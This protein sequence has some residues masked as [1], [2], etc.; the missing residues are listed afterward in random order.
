MRAKD[1][2]I[3]NE[4]SIFCA[5]KNNNAGLLPFRNLF[6]LESLESGT[7]L[8]RRLDLD[9]VTFENFKSVL[10]GDYSR[11]LAINYDLAGL[12]KELQKYLLEM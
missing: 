9:N 12:S 7:C 6:S 5:K 3:R 11:A 1:P 10:Y 8:L 2:Y 4:L